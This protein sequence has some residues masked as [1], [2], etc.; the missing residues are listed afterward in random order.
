MDL[1]TF[2]KL[3]GNI[4][5]QSQNTSSKDS[6]LPNQQ[7]T[8]SYKSS[9]T[10]KPR[11]NITLYSHRFGEQRGKWIMRYWVRLPMTIEKQSVTP[12][13]VKEYAEEFLKNG[14][15]QGDE[16]YVKVEKYTASSLEFSFDHDAWFRDNFMSQ[17]PKYKAPITLDFRYR[18]DLPRFI[19]VNAPI[20]D[21]T[22]FLKE[23]FQKFLE[24]NKRKL[25]HRKFKFL[26]RV[27][28]DLFEYRIDFQ[29]MRFKASL[30]YSVVLSSLALYMYYIHGKDIEPEKEKRLKRDLGRH[31]DIK[32]LERYVKKI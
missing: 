29:S 25:Y 28:P 30:K 23:R 7:K 21:F 24:K 27:S 26:K 3:S 8:R 32:K 14:S 1:R 20:H 16:K 4:H 6:I 31:K 19:Y 10:A 12:Q 13:Q 17:I 15:N 22:K 5:P 11:P 9:E 2:A 18:R